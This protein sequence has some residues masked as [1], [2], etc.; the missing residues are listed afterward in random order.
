MRSVLKQRTLFRYNNGLALLLFIFTLSACNAGREQ[1]E[2]EYNNYSF[3][4][5]VIEK[6]PLYDSMVTAIIAS[7]PSFQKFIRD[8]DGHRS[9]LYL[10]FS[11]DDPDVFIK[12]PPAAAPGIDPYFSRL[13]KDFIY[14][15]EIF[16]DS[17][18]KVY[19]RKK[20]SAGTDVHI[21]E[22]L[23][24]FPNAEIKAREFP[25]KDS[26]LNRNWQY[27]VRFSKESIF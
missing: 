14:G 24:Y 7:S 21:W 27:W 22:S 8:E 23:S 17:S 9:F 6:L 10:P 19:V 16:R 11:T 26:I 3:D 5:Q 2:K 13:G 4:P 1:V 18:I 12:L 25:D 20:N 15:F